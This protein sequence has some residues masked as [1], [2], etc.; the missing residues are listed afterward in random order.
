ML[1]AGERHGLDG[2]LRTGTRTRTARPL[3]RPIFGAFKAK[4]IKASENRPVIRATSN[5]TLFLV[6]MANNQRIP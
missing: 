5:A 6:W 4:K 2:P 1:A 3:A